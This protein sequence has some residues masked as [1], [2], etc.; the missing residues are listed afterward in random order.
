M[1]FKTLSKDKYT[2]GVVQKATEEQRST[3]YGLIGSDNDVQ[4]S[5]LVSSA[6][7][8][9]YGT[10]ICCQSCDSEDIVTGVFITAQ[11]LFLFSSVCVSLYADK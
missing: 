9:E 11:R 7:S 6:R 5:R 3:S 8:H 1:V 2:K 10:F 4:S